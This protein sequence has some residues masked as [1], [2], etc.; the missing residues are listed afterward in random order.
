MQKYSNNMQ[1][2]VDIKKGLKINS[3]H[4]IQKKKTC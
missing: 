3:K 4:L 2:L 1:V